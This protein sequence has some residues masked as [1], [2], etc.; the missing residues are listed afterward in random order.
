[1]KTAA[2]AHAQLLSTPRDELAEFCVDVSKDVYGF[3]MRYLY[4][5][6]M[7]E[8]I[9]WHD[10]IY[11]FNE[12]EQVWN[13]RPHI[14]EMIDAENDY[15]DKEVPARYEEEDNAWLRMCEGE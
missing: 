8:L 10:S 2:Q 11:E 15:W 4:D 9:D 14:R 7:E 13:F 6:S 5:K 3:K 1:M 12:Q